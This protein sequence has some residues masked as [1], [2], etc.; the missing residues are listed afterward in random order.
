[1]DQ[2]QTDQRKSGSLLGYLLG[3]I[4]ILMLGATL[5][6]AS[7]IGFYPHDMPIL[8][9]LAFGGAALLWIAERLM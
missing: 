7:I 2:S 9:V 1:M 3:A 4:G 5:I 6:K 8:A